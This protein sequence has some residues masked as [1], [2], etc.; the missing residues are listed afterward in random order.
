MTEFNSSNLSIKN[1]SDELAE[2]FEYIEN[3]LSKEIPT[4][5]LNSE[6]FILGVLLKK[7]SYAYKRLYAC[8]RSIDLVNFQNSLGERLYRKALTAVKPGV[9]VKYDS[10]FL[11]IVQNAQ[12]IERKNLNSDEL[13]SD[14]ILLSILSDDISI[15]KNLIKQALNNLGLSHTMLLDNINNPTMVHSNQVTNQEYDDK[16]DNVE[17]NDGTTIDSVSVK[18]FGENGELKNAGNFNGKDGIEFLKNIVGEE[19]I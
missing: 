16:S 11:K 1:C 12:D 2:I 7:K 8:L 5:I 10:S 9:D 14:H 19:I 15:E 17:N 18:V 13:R 3:D 6:Y 4:L